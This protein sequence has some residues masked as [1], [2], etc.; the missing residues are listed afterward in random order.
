MLI[1]VEKRFIFVAN[2]KTASTSIE[3]ALMDHAEIHRG[4][5]PARKHIPL[6]QVY[7]FYD[8]LFGQPA[9]RPASYFAFGVMRDPIEWV[10]SWFRYRKGNKVENGL[11]QDMTFAQFW[12]RNDWN[13]TRPDGRRHLQRQMFCDWQ[14]GRAHV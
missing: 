7:K 1:G 13:I 3:H 6:V 5:S 14:I 8:F 12:E 9:H 11:P 4:G 2:T 10:I